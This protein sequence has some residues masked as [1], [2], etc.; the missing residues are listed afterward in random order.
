MERQERTSLQQ[1]YTPA[2]SWRA[3]AG[4]L[5]LTGVVYAG[6]PF[7]ERLSIAPEQEIEHRTVD[8]VAPPPPPAPPPAAPPPPEEAVPRPE[9]TLPEI[10]RTLQPLPAGLDVRMGLG[11]VGGDFSV[12]FAVRSLSDDVASLIYEMGQLDE[13]P[14]PLVQLR[15]MYPPQARLR[16]ISGTVTVEFVVGTDGEVRDVVVTASEPEGVFERAATRAVE[17]WRFSPGIK[18]GEAVPVRVRQRVAFELE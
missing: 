17:R 6:L 14:R 5:L 1:A 9:P 4:A 10:R 12:G 3:V 2:W 8:V 16:Q 13:P 7:L 11:D 18:A 15:P